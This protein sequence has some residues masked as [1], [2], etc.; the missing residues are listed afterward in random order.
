MAVGR[1]QDKYVIGLTGN[2][3]MGK[4]LVRRM[5][6]HLGAYTIDADALAHQAMSPGAPAYKPVV[7]TFG[8]WILDADKRID[9]S[10]LGAIAFAHPEALRRLEAITHPIIERAI[11]TLIARSQHRFVV[12]EAIKLVE[13]PLAGQVDSIWVVNASQETQIARLVKR[14]LSRE[15]ALKRIRA[16]NPQADKLARA[17]VVIDNNGTPEETWGQVRTA[18]LQIAGAARAEALQ[19]APQPVAVSGAGR[20]GGA[21]AA[22]SIVRGTPHTA[23]QIASLILRCTGKRLSHDDVLIAFGQKSY[24]LVVVDEQPVALIGFLVENLVTRV[25]ELLILDGQPVAPITA[26]LIGAVER[27]SRE[28]QSEVGFVFLPPDV[29]PEMAKALRD[30][31]YEAQTLETISVPAWREAAREARPDASAQIFG[32][33][34][35]A[36]RVLKP[37]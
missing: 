28:L 15:E 2:I 31:G 6:E 22:L 3:A 25:D 12:V 8:T 21:L 19:T 29:P 7:L 16:Q 20:D 1:W 13:G 34:L 10:R 27:S 11:D 9:R 30:Q 18:W 37:L 26:A 4:S 17:H 14:G 32:K 24:L 35:R 5:L 33:K 23:D 36:K